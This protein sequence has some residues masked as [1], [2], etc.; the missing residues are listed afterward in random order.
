MQYQCECQNMPIQHNRWY[1]LRNVF[2]SYGAVI[3]YRW[4][5]QWWWWRRHD[6]GDEDE[7]KK[8]HRLVDDND[9]D[10]DDDDDVETNK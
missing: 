7:T 3:C 9:D 8:G 5:W 1:N 10:D 4:W 6:V 2:E